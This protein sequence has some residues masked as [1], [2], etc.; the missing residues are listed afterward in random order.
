MNSQYLI[1]SLEQIRAQYEHL[2]NALKAHKA[3]R[4]SQQLRTEVM[5]VQLHTKPSSAQ[6]NTG[7]ATNQVTKGALSTIGSAATTAGV[8]YDV[9]MSDRAPRSYDENEIETLPNSVTNPMSTRMQ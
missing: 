8:H 9:I 2:L 1:E 3:L 5:K 4:L 6:L 7:G